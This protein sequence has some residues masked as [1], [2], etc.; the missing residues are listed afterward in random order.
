[1]IQTLCLRVYGLS[2]PCWGLFAPT[3]LRPGE[4]RDFHPEVWRSMP[5]GER[6]FP[7][8]CF[9][10]FPNILPFATPSCQKENDLAFYTNAFSLSSCCLR[11]RISFLSVL[12]TVKFSLMHYSWLALWTNRFHSLDF[13]PFTTFVFI[14]SSL[15]ILGF[16]L[17]FRPLAC[18]ILK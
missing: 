13:R 8:R 17:P 16:Y 9:S 5:W 6:P 14:T 2:H 1:M 11:R 7:L 12:S 10:Y 3:D 15:F 18:S 4:E